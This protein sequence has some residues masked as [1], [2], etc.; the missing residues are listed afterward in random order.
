MEPQNIDEAMICSLYHKLLDEWNRR[1][2][3][4]YAALFANESS[5]VGFDGSLMNGRTEIAAEIGRIFADHVTAAYYGKVREVRFLAPGVALLRAVAGM[6]PP[7]QTEINPAANAIHPI[8]RRCR[9]KWYLAHCP[10]PQHPG[11][12]SWTAGTGRAVNQRVTTVTLG[13]ANI[14]M[15]LITV[16]LYAHEG[17]ITALRCFEQEA[18]ALV[19]QFGGEL[20]AAFKPANPDNSADIP[21]EIHPPNDN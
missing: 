3:D 1:N 7:G 20:V 17:N 19:R 21:D 11:P 9:A 16:H 5:V 6:V 14:S 12:V 15:L 8:P 10:F 18:L 4:D 13:S 2:A